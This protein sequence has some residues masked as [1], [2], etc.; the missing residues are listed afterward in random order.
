MTI[1]DQIKDE[2]LQYDINRAAAKISALSSGKTNKYG[3][4]TGEEI[5]PSNQKQIA[6]QAKLTFSQLGKAFEKQKQ[7]TEDQGQKKVDVLKD[8]K[9][10]TQELTIENVILED[11]LNEETKNK[12]KKK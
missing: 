11:I 3:Y 7:T 12:L 10:N 9:S 6:E 2:K 4:L 8:L 1:E 5:L